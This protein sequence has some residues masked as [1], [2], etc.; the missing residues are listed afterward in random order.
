MCQRKYLFVF[1]F[2]L[3]VGYIDNSNLRS[4]KMIIISKNKFIGMYVLM[5][6]EAFKFEVIMHVGDNVIS[7][8][9]V[10]ATLYYVM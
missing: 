2:V 10:I 4:K 7:Y 6:F 1:F 8:T 5:R 3:K 9:Y